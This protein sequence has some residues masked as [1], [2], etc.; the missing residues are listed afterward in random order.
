MSLTGPVDLYERCISCNRL[1]YAAPK[2][3]YCETGF[4]CEPCRV[5]RFEPTKPLDVG[6]LMGVLATC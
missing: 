3:E 2:G 4:L 5:N 6:E 1:A